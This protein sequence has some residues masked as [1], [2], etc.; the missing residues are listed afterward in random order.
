MVGKRWLAH[1]WRGSAGI[2]W[3]SNNPSRPCAYS[4][5]GPFPTAV[6]SALLWTQRHS[7]LPTG[8]ADTPRGQ[9]SWLRLPAARVGLDQ[10]EDLHASYEIARAA[11]GIGK[12]DQ[13]VR[14]PGQ[15]R[16]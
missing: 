12:T 9:L 1:L 15:R 3:T 8:A 14:N 5:Q 2:F 13:G 16:P 4:Q 6:S 11:Q 10:V 7:C